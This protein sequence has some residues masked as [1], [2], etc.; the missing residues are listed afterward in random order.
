MDKIDLKN[1]LY[2]EK[3]E[4]SLKTIDKESRLCYYLCKEGISL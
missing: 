1:T 2:L 3:L 4:F